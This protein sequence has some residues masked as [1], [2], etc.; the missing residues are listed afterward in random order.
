MPTFKDYNK[1][2]GSL[3]ST[4]KVTNAMGMIASIKL[5]KNVKSLENTSPYYIQ[6]K[7]MFHDLGNDIN[8]EG[9]IYLRGY[10]ET[11]KIHI[12]LFTSDKGLCGSHNND[13][14]KFAVKFAN[15][16]K[17]QGQ[18]VCF[19]FI[20]RK[21]RL[22]FEKL[23]FEMLHYYEDVTNK[24]SFYKVKDVSSDLLFEFKHNQ[25]QEVWLIYNRFVSTIE[26]EAV[27]ERLLPASTIYD[28]EIGD[29]NDDV[30]E[31]IIEPSP[32]EFLDVM[33]PKFIDFQLYHTVLRSVVSE[34]AA[35]MAAMEGATANSQDMIDRYTLLRNR[36]RQSSITNE[37]IE[38]I[39][40]KEAMKG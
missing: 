17:E 18:E 22:K 1:K 25:Y 3:Q 31:F 6:L 36:V 4:Q 26:Q 33:I 21:G 30:S 20:G 7:K 24:P 2:I 14:I 29:S 5:Q 15:D 40:G 27:A 34:H 16:L 32:A 13:A 10:E 12:I 28:D 11:K 35:R 23:D 8:K 37:L 38:I 19:S 9:S 39:S